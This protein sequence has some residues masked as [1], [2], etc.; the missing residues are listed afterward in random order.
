MTE[1]PLRFQP[2][3]RHTKSILMLEQAITLRGRHNKKLQQQ[4][5][6]LVIQYKSHYGHL[7][8]D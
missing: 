5:K 4:E 6:Y 8:Y 3:P 7:T 2:L 1:L